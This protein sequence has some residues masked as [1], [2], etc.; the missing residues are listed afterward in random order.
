MNT[1]NIKIA[2]IGGSIGGLSAA[3]VL[4]RL[5]F[6][7]TIFEAFSEG[8]QNRGGTLGAVDLQ[9]LQTILPLGTIQKPIRNHEHFYG[10]LWQYLYE[11]L[12][13]SMVK[14][15]VDIQE[16]LHPESLK[17]RLEIE[18]EFQIFDLIIGADGGKSTI[19]K[20]IADA[21][22][23]IANRAFSSFRDCRAMNLHRQIF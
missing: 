21:T 9:L 11:G 22:L 4:N 1:Q 17:P 19:R 18:G 5:G 12:P 14:F 10:D 3:N 8:F 7:V 6:E 2:V 13:K 15:G 20:Y 23:H 16:I